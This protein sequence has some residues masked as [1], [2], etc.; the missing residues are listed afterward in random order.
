MNVS[1][2]LLLYRYSLDPT[3]RM[4]VLSVFVGGTFFKLQNTSINQATIQRFMSLP[5]LKHIKQTLF[6]FSIGLTL[7]YMGCIYVGLVC[8][9]VYYDCDPMATGVSLTCSSFRVPSYSLPFAYVCSW[10]DVGISSCHFW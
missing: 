7:L 8:F 1:F 4:S 3:V 9:A 6:T 2:F 5:S 10:L